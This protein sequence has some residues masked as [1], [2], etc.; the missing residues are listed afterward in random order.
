MYLVDVRFGGD[1]KNIN[2][3]RVDA[4]ACLNSKDLK[5]LVNDL[6]NILVQI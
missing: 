1:K 5:I 4:D 2:F 3:N 6:N